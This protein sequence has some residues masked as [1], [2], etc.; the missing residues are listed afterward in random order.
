MA[1]KQDPEDEITPVGPGVED[2]EST[3]VEQASDAGAGED[4]EYPE[5]DDVDSPGRHEAGDE[6]TG[7]AENDPDDDGAG[8]SREQKR[9]RR[10]REKYERD[11]RELGYLRSRNEQL[12]REQSRRLAVVESRQ[13]Q[14][15]V[16]AIDGRIAQAQSDVREAESLYTEALKT[17]NPEA[18]TEALRVRDDLRDGLRNLQGAKQQT[19]RAAQERRAT[20]TQPPTQDPVIQQRAQDWAR[21]HTWFDPQARDEDS[22]I[23]YAVERRVF[24]EGRLSPRSN[25]YWDEVDRRLA[26]RLPEHY[27][28]QGN[29]D[30]SD[31]TRAQ[32]DSGRRVNGSRKASGPTI[33]VSGR[34]RTLRK[35]E[36]YIDED[37]KAAMIEKGVWDDPVLRERQLKYFQQYDREAGRRPK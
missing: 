26:K 7:H 29:D 36:V 17:N 34:E 21:E 10:K 9:R 1:E 28:D 19:V 31:D 18:A 24:A 3:V 14:S 16:L 6:R 5:G 37:R 30:D 4:Y 23:A 15:D 2:D 22:A 20:A 12:E 27:R 13:T 25:E 11:Q 32:R 8:L 35:G 33:K